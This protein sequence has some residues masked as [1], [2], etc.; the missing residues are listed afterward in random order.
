MRANFPL[1]IVGRV[2][3]PEDARVATGRGGSKAENLEGR[4]D[5]LAILAQ[6]GVRFQAPQ[7]TPAVVDRLLSQ[8]QLPRR[9]PP[10]ARDVA[11]EVQVKSQPVQSP[12][13]ALAVVASDDL[14][15]LAA[16][17]H[18]WLQAN[19]GYTKTG[20]VHFLFGDDTAPAGNYWYQALAAL[21]KAEGND[22]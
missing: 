4:G 8:A 22:E 19:P 14:E 1:R 2:V 11:V 17:L 13:T 20:V 15:I 9:R 18:P 16:R 3:S 10:R 12:E 5:F 7:A 21:K 6:R